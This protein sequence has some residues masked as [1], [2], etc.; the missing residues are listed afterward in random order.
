LRERGRRRQPHARRHDRS[1]EYKSKSAAAAGDS[2]PV[3]SRGLGPG[4]PIRLMI[5]LVNMVVVLFPLE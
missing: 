4:L 5:R 1:G 2:E 3:F